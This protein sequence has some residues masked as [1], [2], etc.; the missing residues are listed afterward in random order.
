MREL[1]DGQKPRA[2][3]GRSPGLRVELPAA[4]GGGLPHAQADNREQGGGSARTGSITPSQFV[5]AKSPG[6]EPGTRL[7][8]MDTPRA[9][10]RGFTPF[11]GESMSTLSL[12]GWTHHSAPTASVSPSA[13]C[14]RQVGPGGL[15]DQDLRVGDRSRPVTLT[16]FGGR[17]TIPLRLRRSSERSVVATS[18]RPGDEVSRLKIWEVSGGKEVWTIPSLDRQAFLGDAWRSARTEP[19]SRS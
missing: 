19:A 2:G 5:A 12:V 15:A 7:R 4:A 6:G 9:A 3:R 14:S 10:V 16:D 1:L 11:P 18:Q 17:R 13:P 8:L